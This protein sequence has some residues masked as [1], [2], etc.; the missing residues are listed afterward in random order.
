M[1][2]CEISERILLAQVRMFDLAERHYGLTLKVLHLETQIPLDS[3]RC[4][5]GKVKSR[6][7]TQMP[8]GVFVKLARVIPD[9]LSS[10]PMEESG[11]VIA[12]AEPDDHD[13]DDLARA[14]DGRFASEQRL[15]VIEVARKLR[16]EM[17]DRQWKYG[18]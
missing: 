12:D 8:L 1:A 14:D 16:A 15:K 4:Y 3:L 5:A 18:K 11:K 2:E 17:P 7:V 13:V 10:L 9:E 6:T